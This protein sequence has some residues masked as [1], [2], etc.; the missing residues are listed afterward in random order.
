VGHDEKAV[1]IAQLSDGRLVSGGTLGNPAHIW[2]KTK[3]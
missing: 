3:N 2:N 1:Y